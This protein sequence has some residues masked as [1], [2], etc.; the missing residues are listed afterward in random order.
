MLTNWNL[1]KNLKQTTKL[2]GQG[3]SSKPKSTTFGSIF[4]GLF[5]AY[6][7]SN[8]GWQERPIYNGLSGIQDNKGLISTHTECL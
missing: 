3:H 5:L 8:G 6:D 2:N 4:Q 1:N 7:L